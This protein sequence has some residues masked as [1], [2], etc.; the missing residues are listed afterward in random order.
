MVSG[1]A[2]MRGSR[3]RASSCGS[4]SPARIASRMAKPVTPGMSLSTWGSCRFIWGGAFCM[5][6]EEG[7]PVPAGGPHGDGGDAPLR[8]PRGQGQQILGEGPEAPD[9]LRVAVEGYADVELGG[10]EV[11][12]RRG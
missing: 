3:C 12:A 4:R 5:C 1:E 6:W 8:E 9:G 2:L 10:A 7:D 11:D